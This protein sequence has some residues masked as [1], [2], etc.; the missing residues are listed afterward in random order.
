MENFWTSNELFTYLLLYAAQ[1]NYIETEEEKMFIQER[2]DEETYKKIK[3]ELKNDNDFQSFE[4]IESGIKF[5][6]YT[7]DDIKTILEEVERLFYSDGSFDAIEKNMMMCL[8][9]ILK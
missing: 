2:V 7:K 3:L 5:Y 8:K 1:A 4:K 9:R 6:K